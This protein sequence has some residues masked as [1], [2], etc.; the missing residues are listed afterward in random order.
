[1][2]DLDLQCLPMSHQKE[3]GIIWVKSVKY[4]F[5]SK[6]RRAVIDMDNKRIV[7]RKFYCRIY[8]FDVFFYIP[9]IACL[10]KIG[11]LRRA[12]H[13]QQWRPANAQASLCFST[14]SPGHSLLA[15][16]QTYG[17]ILRS[18]PSSVPLAFAGKLRMRVHKKDVTHVR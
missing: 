15:H 4:Y 3:A 11:R 10:N 18:R 12:R 16:T 13:F 9:Y 8:V 7:T 5:S 2:S 1:M 14:V 6:T 17:S